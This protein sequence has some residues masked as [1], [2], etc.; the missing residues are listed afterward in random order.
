[1]IKTNFTTEEAQDQELENLVQNHTSSDSYPSMPVEDDTPLEISRSRC[2]DSLYPED[3]LLCQLEEDQMVIPTQ[4]PIM[5]FMLKVNDKG[6]AHTNTE[7]RDSVVQQSL[8]EQLTYPESRPVYDIYLRT[9]KSIRLTIKEAIHRI[10]IRLMRAEW[11]EIIDRRPLYD[12][13]RRYF[14]EECYMFR[15]LEKGAECHISN[16]MFNTSL[17]KYN[18][19][20]SN[21]LLKAEEIDF[22]SMALKVF[23]KDN[24]HQ[25]PDAIQTVLDMRFRYPHMVKSLLIAG[26][27]DNNYSNKHPFLRLP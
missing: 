7:T 19:M 13:V 8:D 1:M 21:P 17:R 2:L 4:N 11:K 20:E 24:E 27:L 22:L 23:G 15:F 18:A 12:P 10:A 9:L 26:T 25:L 3:R 5:V 6:F 14:Y 16:S